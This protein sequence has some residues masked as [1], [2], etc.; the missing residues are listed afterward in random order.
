MT[1]SK[2]IHLVAVLLS[3][4]LI[5]SGN[6]RADMPAPEGQL[7]VYF[8]DVTSVRMEKIFASCPNKVCSSPKEKVFHLRGHVQET[9]SSG[10]VASVQL[11]ALDVTFGNIQEALNCFRAARKASRKGLPL[12]IVGNGV[13]SSPGSGTPPSAGAPPIESQSASAVSRSEAELSEELLRAHFTNISSCEVGS[14]SIDSENP[15]GL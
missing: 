1:I 12:S 13:L 8:D 7:S 14:E 15:V 10:D 6:A 11:V 9:Q 5:S 2:T 4:A 3:G